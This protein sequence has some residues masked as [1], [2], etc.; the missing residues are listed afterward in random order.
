MVS[1]IVLAYNNWQVTR[2]C[3]ASVAAHADACELELVLLDNASSDETPDSAHA[4]RNAFGGF[5]V[6]RQRI[7]QPCSI[8]LNRAARVAS[9]RHLLFL[10]NDIEL[11]PGALR[12]ME[13]VLARESEVGVVGGRLSYPGGE[14]IQHAGV[15]PMLWGHPVN[16]GVGASRSD[17]RF[18]IA[19]SAFAVTGAMLMARREAFDAV[20]GFD[21]GYVWG[22]EDVD[23]CL[24]VRKAGWS[25]RYDPA[26][27]ALHHE[28]LTLRAQMPSQSANLLRYRHRWHDVLGQ[29]EEAYLASLSRRG[30]RRF[31]VWGTGSA[32][33][34]VAAV[35]QSH[36]FEV[37]GFVGG[38]THGQ[39]SVE[40]SLPT[41]ETPTAAQ[42]SRH[43]AII[44]A[45][46]SFYRFESR[47]PPGALFPIV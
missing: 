28:S 47:V 32:G 25:V 10:N 29:R 41:W 44:V 18:A 39:T 13:A 37:A 45:S 38:T 9:G 31:L 33:R 15:V 21:E 26:A 22:F 7:N 1:V 40:P 5:V 36:G 2:R 35:L 14:T 30:L 4:F 23:L 42:A 34:G 46:Q 11:M 16:H 17:P 3:L 43:D 12:A 24:G 6:E 27:Q 20:G 19:G 8:A